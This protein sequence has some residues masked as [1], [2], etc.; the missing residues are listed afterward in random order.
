M[1]T[2][3]KYTLP[4]FF[5]VLG[6]V[7]TGAAYTSLLHPYFERFTAMLYKVGNFMGNNDN[8]ILEKESVNRKKTMQHL[9]YNYKTEKEMTMDALLDKINEKGMQA[10]SKEE[11]KRLE[12]FSKNP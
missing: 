1:V 6:G 12:E 5:M 3:E 7:L 2:I 9:N 8:F 10:L 11:R 4:L